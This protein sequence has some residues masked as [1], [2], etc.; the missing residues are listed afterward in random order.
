MEFAISLVFTNYA[1]VFILFPKI[2]DD[3]FH[4]EIVYIHTFIALIFRILCF[5]VHLTTTFTEVLF[6]GFLKILSPD[7]VNYSFPIKTT[8]IT[9]EYEITQKSLGSGING[10][11]LKCIHKATGTPRALKVRTDS[12]C[13]IFGRFLVTMRK[14][15]VK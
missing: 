3:K 6:V 13:P 5:L 14:L 7:M 8:P 10:K 2:K 15:T 4:S 9:A 11:V 12:L 1:L